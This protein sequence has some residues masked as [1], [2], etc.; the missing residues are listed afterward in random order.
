MRKARNRFLQTCV[1][2]LKTRAK[3]LLFSESGT[4]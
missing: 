4:G 3:N 1:V 2:R